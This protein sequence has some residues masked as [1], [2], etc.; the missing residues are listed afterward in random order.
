MS[1][2]QNR[3]KYCA[4]REIFRCPVVKRMVEPG[5]EIYNCKHFKPKDRGMPREQKK[6]GSLGG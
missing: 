4:V 3:C 1:E 5:N 6:R 2:I